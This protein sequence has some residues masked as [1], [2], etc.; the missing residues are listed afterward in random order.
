M[1]F[2]SGRKSTCHLPESLA[3]CQGFGVAVRWA[4]TLK[5]DSEQIKSVLGRCLRLRCPACGQSKIVTH[6]FH[7][8][9]HC[10]HCMALFKRED[11]FFVGAILANVVTTEIVILLV[12]FFCLLIVGAKYE[13]VLVL[14]FAMALIF[15]IAFYH[16]SWSLWLGFDYIVESLPKAQPQKDTNGTKN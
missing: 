14:L 4:T 10:P 3:A 5:V 16:H 6:P 1:I 7:I 13:N 12:C 2:A 9:H 8:R 11:G 15:P